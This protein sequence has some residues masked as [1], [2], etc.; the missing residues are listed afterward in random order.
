[1]LRPGSSVSYNSAMSHVSIDAHPTEP[2]VVVRIEQSTGSS[3]PNPL[4]KR[5][6]PANIRETSASQK[7]INLKELSPDTDIKALAAVILQ[8]CA[9]IPATSKNQLEQVL[10]YL[11]KRGNQRIS[12]ARSRSSSAVSFDRRPLTSTVQNVD[13]SKV[14]EYMECFY[15]ETSAEKNKGAVALCEL[16]KCAQNLNQLATNETLM[17]AL[18][19]VFREDW[20]KH[21]EVATNIM[22]VFVN[23]SRFTKFHEI[24]LHHKIGSLCVNAMEHETKRYDLWA[25]EMKKADQET[26]RKLKTAIRKQGMLLAACITLL[27]NLATDISV[28]LKMVR[29]N[30]TVLLV[31]CLQMSLNP[32]SSLTLATVRFL[33]KLSIFEENKAVM[34]QNGTVEKVLKLFPIQDPELRKV[35]IKL[36]FNFSFD[37]KNVPKMVDGGLVPHMASL[38]EEDQKALNM[39]YLLSCNDDAKAMLAYTDAIQLLMRDLLS[40]TGSQVTKAVLLNICLEKRNAQLV[41][42]PSGQGLDLLMELSTASKDLMLIKVIRAISTHEGAT[43]NM[44]LKWMENLL[45]IAMTDGTDTSESKSSFGLECMGTVAELKPAPWAKIMQSKGLVSWMKTVLHE[46]IDESEEITVL[47]EIKPL[48]LQIVIACGTMARQLDAA[49]LLVPLIDTFVHLLQSSQID[50]EFV[51]QLLYVFLQLLKHKELSARLMTQDS[52]LAHHMIDLMHD[53]NSAVREVCDNALLI[54]GE[55]SKEWAKRIAGERFKWHN[56]Q[57]LEMVERDDQEFVQQYDD[58]DFGA[59][60]NFDHYEDGF[61]MNEPLF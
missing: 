55:H 21:F 51:V 16:S 15:G 52:T 9:Y 57:W 56:A 49:R 48:Q 10:Y 14:D 6:S 24:L 2:A 43:Q 40:G 39:L 46:G 58:E 38:I 35:A 33:L 60:L 25:N 59:D 45:D 1:M 7:I 13:I 5:A 53:A 26:Q 34:E 37:P 4:R 28:E 19:R 36:L 27:T 50:D 44:F 12:S 41:C 29:R 3:S 8:K 47:R 61:D 30:L 42:G 17:M 22:N 11:Q 20:K 32:A 18:A 31:K 54:M 23:L